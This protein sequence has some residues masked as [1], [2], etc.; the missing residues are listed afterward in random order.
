MTTGLLHGR[1]HLKLGLQA[2]MDIGMWNRIVKVTKIYLLFCVAIVGVTTIGVC[3]I[4][5][6]D[7]Q[8]V[9]SNIVTSVPIEGVPTNDVEIER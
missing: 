4:A 6:D 9:Q 3:Y 5:Y 1:E 2:K 8:Q 7:Y